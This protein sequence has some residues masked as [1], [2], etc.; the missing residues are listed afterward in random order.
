MKLLYLT[1]AGLLPAFAAFAQRNYVPGTLLLPG[2]D[3]L[4]GQIDYRKWDVSPLTINF[5]ATEGAA[6]QE[7]TPASLKGFKIA[8][9]NEI[10]LS[11]PAV[12]DVTNEKVDVLSAGPAR[13]TIGGHHFFR[14]MMDGPVKLLLYTDRFHR[15][16]FA[17]ME[18]GSA[19]QLVRKQVYID[20]PESTDYGKIKTY[21]LYRQQLA[22]V[23]NGCVPH[24][25]LALL[26][27]SEAALRKALQQY[28]ACRYPGETVVV[29]AVEKD[30]RAS[31]GIMGGA[32]LN[33]LSVN[34]AHP[35]ATGKYGN[36]IAP[37]AGVFLDV[38]LSRYRQK[39][40]WANEVIYTTRAMES[41]Y[42]RI[43]YSNEVDVNLRFLQIQ[44]LVRY[45]IPKSGLR[46]YFTAG[47]AGAINL[48]GK[49]DL[50]RT[51]EG[52]TERQR[53]PALEGG[54][55]FF[56]PLLAGAGIRYNK[57]HAELRVVMPHNISLFR[58]LE[59][60]NVTP[61]LLVRYSLF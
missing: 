12:L 50:W 33:I 17:V 40:V 44:T 10:Y 54:R 43:G 35:L 41:T 6:P 49:D 52:Q 21:A 22:A 19:T 45:T 34:G 37:V 26:D 57:L 32:G 36:N 3:S 31:F 39:L 2:G 55:E 60:M 1:L 8:G 48:G 53:E 29:R 25:R 58:M 46:P 7:Y 15:Q 5:R 42:S 9:N 18:K 11:L 56:L 27:Y 28:V 61:Q 20:N 30:M 47:V 16:H 4:S 23:L 13:D 24:Q 51:R 59:V 14:V 38:P